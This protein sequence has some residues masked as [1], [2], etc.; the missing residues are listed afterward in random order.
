MHG[1]GHDPSRRPA[2]IRGLDNP[3]QATR[4]HSLRFSQTHYQRNL[5]SRPGRKNRAL[6]RNHGVAHRDIRCSS[7]VSSRS[8]LT[9]RV[10]Y[11]GAR[12]SG[13]T[14]RPGELQ[15]QCKSKMIMQNS[16]FG[17]FHFSIL[18][19]AF[20]VLCGNHHADERRST[21]AGCGASQALTPRRVPLDEAVGLF[22]LRHRQRSQFAAVR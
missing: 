20:S 19:F 7:A 1:R 12:S 9:L 18:H 3:F 6:P 14:F 4:V 15:K 5:K 8:Y 11:P 10:R 22:W 17:I 16:N 21:E 2:A 13:L